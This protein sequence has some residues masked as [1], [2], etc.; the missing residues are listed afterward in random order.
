VSYTRVKA[1]LRLE[2]STTTIR[3]TLKA[4]SYR[5]CAACPC[6]FILKKQVIKHLTFALKY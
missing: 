5:R 6:P 2:V 1:E 3:R 4:Y